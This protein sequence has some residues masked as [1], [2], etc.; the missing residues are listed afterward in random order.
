MQSH[1]SKT[2]TM[3]LMGQFGHREHNPKVEMDQSFKPALDLGQLLRGCFQRGQTELQKMQDLKSLMAEVKQSKLKLQDNLEEE[4]SF[5]NPE[6]R[7]EDLEALQEL[8]QVYEEARQEILDFGYKNIDLGILN[9][10]KLD[11]K[12]YSNT[13]QEKVQSN[14]KAD[15][16]VTLFFT[17]RG[18]A[19]SSKQE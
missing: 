10:A 17:F 16:S 9:I 11:Y 4:V 7:K 8:D 14:I 1:L 15:A 19:R 6:K 18:L 5:R 2:K 12:D 13:G 3:G